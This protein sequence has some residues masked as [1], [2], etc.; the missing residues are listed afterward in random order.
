M[1]TTPEHPLLDL[2]DAGIR[3]ARIR[4]RT[5]AGDRVIGAAAGP[6]DDI[7]IRIDHPRFFDRVLAHGNLGL[8]ESYMDADFA[9]ERGTLEDL[10]VVLLSDRVDRRVAPGPRLAARAATV[11]L[12]VWLR[13]KRE[14]VRRHYDLGIDLFES[15][16]DESLAYSCGYA[17]D[18]GDSLEG[19]QHNKYERI[20]CKLRL[21]PGDT[22]VDVGCGFAGLLIH[23]AK[24]YG[25]RGLGVTNS[26]EHASVARD[27]VSKAQIDRRLEIQ[28]GDYRDVRGR[29]SKLVSVGMLEHVPQ[30]EVTAYFRQVARML[31]PDGIGLVHTIG[32]NGAHGRHD[33]FI[34]KYIF[35]GSRQPRLSEIVA[36]LERRGLAI[37]DVENV[38]RHYVPTARHWLARFLANA[39]SLDPARYDDRF[40]R[41]WEYY[42]S[43]GIAAAAASDAAVYQVLFTP[44]RAAAIPLERV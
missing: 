39:R 16:L 28:L 41:M 25:V 5:A 43:C 19:L 36:Q 4:F 7:V 24:R 3:S 9:L 30:R 15:F 29:Y 21:V 35:P 20:C 8:A 2:L 22:L 17:R 32:H 27:R 42:L 26:V 11:Y 10:L 37:L 38:V 14:N 18:P 13:G 40:R 31:A 6:D 33:P 34:Q 1:R 12:R 44:D 23:A